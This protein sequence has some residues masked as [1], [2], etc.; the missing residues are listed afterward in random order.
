MNENLLQYT[1]LLKYET[2][3]GNPIKLGKTLIKF[4][5]QGDIKEHTMLMT[6]IKA[7]RNF[8]F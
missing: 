2:R 1:S 6:V 4:I 8:I 3:V 7:R 5:S